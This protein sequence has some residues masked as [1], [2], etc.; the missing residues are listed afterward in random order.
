[1]PEAN[2]DACCLIDLLASGDAEAILRFRDRSGRVYFDLERKV[3]MFGN[4]PVNMIFAASSREYPCSII[5]V[6]S[7]SSVANT[8]DAG[9]PSDT[10]S[11]NR[12]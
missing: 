5:Q 11:Y 7:P 10:F 2:I 8:G 6:P 1:M 9:V 12:T 4:L 3:L